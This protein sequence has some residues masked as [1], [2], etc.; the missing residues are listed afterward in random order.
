MPTCQNAADFLQSVF[1]GA[2]LDLKVSASETS[3]SC[4]LNMEGDDAGF[5]LNEGGEFLDAVQHLTSQIFGR[6]MPEG[7][8]FV[9]DVENFRATREAELAAMA[10]HAAV[11]VRKTGSVFLFGPMTANE[12]RVIHT[13]LATETDLHTES[14]G[15]GAAR[16][17]RVSP[18]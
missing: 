17:L 13:A 12:R 7:K 10:K 14:V 18:K 3:D 6:D 1:D 8:R 2:H 15:E 5:L 16:R 11:Q 4:V 9:C